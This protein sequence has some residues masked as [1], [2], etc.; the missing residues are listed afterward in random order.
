VPL[1]ELERLER[2][3]KDAAK[4]KR[5]RMDFSPCCVLMPD[6]RRSAAEDYAGRRAMVRVKAIK[7]IWPFREPFL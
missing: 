7:I 6:K 4:A 5:L 2:V 1:A 3:E